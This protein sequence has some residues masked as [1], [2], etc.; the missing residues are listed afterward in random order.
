MVRA[1]GRIAVIAVLA[2]TVA[3]GCAPTTPSATPRSA[4]AA[5]ALSGTLTIY[6]AASLAAAFEVI[7]RE[8]AEL[9]DQ[10]DVR[11]L[12]VSGSTTLATQLGEGAL[13]DVLVVADENTMATAAAAGTVYDEA[14]VIATN[15]VTLIVPLDSPG[16]ITELDDLVDARLRVVLCAAKVP[17]GAASQR[18]L[19][20]AGLEVSAASFS[21]ASQ[22]C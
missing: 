14:I 7:V 18:L 20:S 8:F 19:H 5:N 17:C 6:T 21:K 1:P 9:H 15:T 13:A 11:P 16:A 12:V 22:Q 10:L 4:A 3:S 2:L